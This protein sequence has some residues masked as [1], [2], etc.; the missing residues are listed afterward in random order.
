MKSI[1][2]TIMC[3]CL[4]MMPVLAH[5]Q[6]AAAISKMLSKGAKTAMKS[7]INIP[8]LDMAQAGD[9][10]LGLADAVTSGV[11]GALKS[12]KKLGMWSLDG[13]SATQLAEIATSD[14][15]FSSI[16]TMKG[17]NVYKE[18]SDLI[19]TGLDESGASDL[20]GNMTGVAGFE[21]PSGG[22]DGFTRSVTENTLDALDKAG[23]QYL[24]KL[25]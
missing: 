11:N 23:A 8:G 18:F 20:I 22:K 19:G 4:L 9:K 3:A 16:L 24:Q 5:A 10:G 21:M 7:S 1:H 12:A 15:P 14:T 17:N 6:N 13:L 25:K 2:V